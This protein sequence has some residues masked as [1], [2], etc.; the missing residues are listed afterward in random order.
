MMLMVGCCKVERCK[1]ENADRKGEPRANNDRN[2][3]I[4]VVCVKE[5]Q[6]ES[7]TGL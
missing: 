6:G 1:G 5:E 7:E 3:C 2:A 4:V